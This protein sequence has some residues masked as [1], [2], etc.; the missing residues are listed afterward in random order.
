M[1]NKKR[2]Y[3]AEKPEQLQM[4]MTA[5]EIEAKYQPLDADRHEMNDYPSTRTGGTLP[6]DY[7]SLN[8]PGGRE[9]F[10]TYTRASGGKL[11]A[12]PSRRMVWDDNKVET[13]DQLWDRKSD[14]AYNEIEVSL[15]RGG[16][17][18]QRPMTTGGRSNISRWTYQTD[19]TDPGAYTERRAGYWRPDQGGSLGES[20]ER[21]GVQKPISL[22]ET[23]GSQGKPEIVGGHH[24]L[25]VMRN[26]NPDQY[27]PVVHHRSILHA[28]NDRGY[29]YS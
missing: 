22:G 16:E 5:R 4:F 19:T 11:K 10:N 28:K 9:R 25:A 3:R 24:R 20:I 12:R 26:L 17:T 6:T 21:T 29:K 15:P 8:T 7:S 23:I 2:F 27:L 18:T 13:D 14:E 1:A